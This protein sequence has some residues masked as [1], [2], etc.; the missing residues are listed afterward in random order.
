MLASLTPREER[1][2]RMR[3]GIGPMKAPITRWKKSA[4]NSRLTRE[5]YP[6]DRSEGAAQAQASEPVAQ[7]AVSFLDQ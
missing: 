5:T 4:S 1:V 6:P 2:L 7:D 3:F